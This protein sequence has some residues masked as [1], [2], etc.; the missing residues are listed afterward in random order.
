MANNSNI[1]ISN[2][3][4]LN[5]FLKLAYILKES[6][7]V[8]EKSTSSNE[9]KK[10]QEKSVSSNEIIG[11]Q[12]SNNY[13]TYIPKSS[14]YIKSIEIPSIVIKSSYTIPV[15]YVQP[16]IEDLLTKG[17][18][19]F[20]KRNLSY[21]YSYNLQN[22]IPNPLY[23]KYI[24]DKYN[25]DLYATGDLDGENN[26]TYLRLNKNNISN[27]I[28]KDYYIPSIGEL[29]I[30]MENIQKIND[31]IEKLGPE[32]SNYKIPYDSII[33]SS[34]LYSQQKVLNSE[35]NVTNN[36]NNVWSFNSNNAEISYRSISNKYTIIPFYKF[37][38]NI[39]I[40]LD[41]DIEDVVVNS[42]V[43]L[44]KYNPNEYYELN[45][46]INNY[47]SR[48]KNI[49][50]FN[51]DNWVEHPFN[52]KYFFNIS[53]PEV[54][55]Y[56]KEGDN[57]IK[58][59]NNYLSYYEFNSYY[60]QYNGK[61]PNIQT[62]YNNSNTYYVNIDIENNDFCKGN[63]IWNNGVS[64]STYIIKKYSHVS[65]V[66]IHDSWNPGIT[67]TYRYTK[68]SDN[69]YDYHIY[70]YINNDS[71]EY[72]FTYISYQLCM[73]YNDYWK[74]ILIYNVP[75]YNNH[76]VLTPVYGSGEQNY[77]FKK[78]QTKSTFYVTI[79]SSCTKF[80][81]QMDNTTDCDI[82]I[83][84]YLEVY[85]F[86]IYCVSL[87]FKV[88]VPTDNILTFS[89]YY[90]GN[91]ISKK[92]FYTIYSL[93][94]CNG[95]YNNSD[96]TTYFDI[97]NYY[98]AKDPYYWWETNNW[99]N[100][101]NKNNIYTSQL[102]FASQT[103]N[104]LIYKYTINDSFGKLFDRSFEK[105]DNRFIAYTYTENLNEE[106]GKIET[107]INDYWITTINDYYSFNTYT[108]NKYNSLFNKLSHTYF[109]GMYD[110]SY[111]INSISRNIGIKD[112]GTIQDRG[113][114]VDRL[115]DN[116]IIN[117]SQLFEEENNYYLIHD[118]KTNILV[119][120]TYSYIYYQPK[121]EFKYTKPSMGNYVIP[122]YEEDYRHSLTNNYHMFSINT[123]INNPNS[124][125]HDKIIYL[126]SN[127]YES[128]LFYKPI[129]RI[130]RNIDNFGIYDDLIFAYIP[131]YY[132]YE[133]N[134]PVSY[135]INGTLLV[136]QISYTS[137]E[138][139]E[140]R[141]IKI[142]GNNGNLSYLKVKM[143]GKYNPNTRIPD[144]KTPYL[145][146]LTNNY[147]YHR[148]ESIPS[149]EIVSIISS[150]PA[151]NNSKIK[152]N[153]PI[154][155]AK[156]SICLAMDM[157]EYINIGLFRKVLTNE[158]G[159]IFSKNIKNNI[160]LATTDENINNQI[161]S[162][163][164]FYE[165]G[166]DNYINI[167]NEGTNEEKLKSS[168]WYYKLNSESL[169]SVYDHMKID[170]KGSFWFDYT[171]YYNY[172]FSDYLFLYNNTNTVITLLIS[173]P[174][175]TLI[176]KQH[177]Q[178][179]LKPYEL[180]L[181]YPNNFNYNDTNNFNK[182]KIYTLKIINKTDSILNMEFEHYKLGE[183]NLSFDEMYNIFIKDNIDFIEYVDNNRMIEH[184]NENDFPKF[185]LNGIMPDQ[186]GYKLVTNL[187]G[188][189]KKCNSSN[190]YSKDQILSLYNNIL[191]YKNTN[192]TE[193]DYHTELAKAI[194]NKLKDNINILSKN[195]NTLNIDIR[196]YSE[197]KAG[198][199]VIIESNKKFKE[200]SYK[201]NINSL[202][203]L[204]FRDD[205]IN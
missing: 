185:K 29:G 44:I 163:S 104:C 190:H 18:L 70:T 125:K 178:I 146:T 38:N 141:K 87:N 127:Y 80:N 159:Q 9:S 137:T 55:N 160:I 52:P 123:Y 204:E 78:N 201:Y 21:S 96:Y 27:Q 139:L 134:Y 83:S 193:N 173:D 136:D 82:L 156:Q 59:H 33:V 154:V 170:F 124:Y 1:Q 186:I 34:S 69:E 90:K 181:Y 57:F 64:Y 2:N 99:N 58:L 76:L 8:S 47:K 79:P 91:Q 85:G 118:N 17:K 182:S 132:S 30:S 108:Y 48:I 13:T 177:A 200:E 180:K 202:E 25:N 50:D 81:C 175:L 63:L 129:I 88:D 130:N 153:I 188:L 7:D 111:L 152:I 140:Y 32:Y 157:I 135:M 176:N 11:Q 43:T 74:N 102:Q 167:I 40:N 196:N 142:M 133:C 105:I 54:K 46:P 36:L 198:H 107:E 197:N 179:Q 28:S 68:I 144:D 187:L 77:N 89:C 113:L 31:S 191:N 120:G 168:G 114:R 5:S 60:I 101:I 62:I 86:T 109:N 14:S 138:S 16:K 169:K 165:K 94:I 172:V 183:Y 106:T 203:G 4:V 195:I 71:S 166:F 66:H 147:I 121:Y 148:D 26:T 19:I 20:S 161:I 189:Y 42:I 103:N 199:L 45:S 184:N 93:L 174:S 15:S 145:Y 39:K 116:D 143:N 98:V 23:N 131:K 117:N 112:N 122:I 67:F 150:V 205:P 164:Y 155:G 100:I 22:I 115:I 10:Y 24:N 56:L 75:I 192:K 12:K 194:H 53:F 95:L 61:E 151:G 3:N 73:N 149:N 51:T 92:Y 97:E 162:N 37:E 119:N 41:E 126:K 6:L 65:Y 158:N 110:M 72:T 128:S 84:K 49:S 171:Y 35:Y